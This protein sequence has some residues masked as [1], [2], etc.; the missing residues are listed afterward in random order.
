MKLTRKLLEFFF[1]IVD[2]YDRQ[3]FGPMS[4]EKKLV[5]WYA[6]WIFLCL[7]P[8]GAFWYLFGDSVATG[9][10][11]FSNDGPI[12]VMNSDWIRYGYPPGEPMWNDLYWIGSGSGR[13]PLMFTNIFY[14]L[15]TNPTAFITAFTFTI[16]CI[17]YALRNRYHKSLLPYEPERCED[18]A[19]PSNPPL[20]K[21][22]AVLCHRFVFMC[23]F[24]RF[25]WVYFATLDKP[26]TITDVLFPLEGFIWLAYLLLGL[27]YWVQTEVEHYDY[28]R[29][30]S[31]R[32]SK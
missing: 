27:V 23:M 19:S 31:K 12:G 26:W 2:K 28:M 17:V 1:P 14:W 9:K 18:D 15:C 21:S 16:L 4:F 29:I 13:S 20:D 32:S 7:L 5:Y 24:A 22:T 3:V 10:I 11:M 25:T 6:P 30:C 8:L